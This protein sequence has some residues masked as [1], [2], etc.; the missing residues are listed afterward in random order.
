MTDLTI[1]VKTDKATY[2]YK[3]F[4]IDSDNWNTVAGNY[5]FTYKASNGK[6]T[7]LYAGITENFKE[8]FADHERIDEAKKL[9]ATHIFAH[10]NKNAN[11]RSSEEEDIIGYY[12]PR[13][14]DKH[15]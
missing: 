15:K 13:M 1:D 7:I 2:S 4:D 3:G 14:N 6:W 5:L 9:G 11:A 10:V 12:Q 8:R